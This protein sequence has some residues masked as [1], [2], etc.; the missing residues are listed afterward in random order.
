MEFVH[1]KLIYLKEKNIKTTAINWHECSIPKLKIQLL[2][3]NK[4]HNL[5]KTT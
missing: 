3:L 1:R 4:F 5:N 2:R